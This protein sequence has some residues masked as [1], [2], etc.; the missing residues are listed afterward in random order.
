M[1]LEKNPLPFITGTISAHNCMSKCTRNFYESPVD[2]RRAKREAAE[3]GFAEN[4]AQ[5]KAAAAAR[6]A[7]GK[8]AAVVGGGPAGLAAA[9][10]LARAE[11]RQ[12]FLRKN[13]PL[14]VWCGG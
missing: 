3:G 13:M 14:A 4:L 12:R 7:S 2:I 8:T 10:F 5:L 1:I 6:A 9:Y 11:L